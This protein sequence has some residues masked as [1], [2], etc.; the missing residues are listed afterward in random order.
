MLE[1]L[2]PKFD[3]LIFTRYYN[4]PRGLAAETIAELA[5]KADLRPT[6]YQVAHDSAAAWQ[7]AAAMAG[8][9]DLICITG[10]FFIAAEMR[11]AIQVAKD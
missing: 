9:D 11:A 6:G 7:L 3:E 8:R 10:S 5:A 1:V 2:G 4:N